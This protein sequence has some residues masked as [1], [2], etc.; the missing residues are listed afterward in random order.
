MAKL[1]RRQRQK[2]ILWTQYVLF[3]LVIGLVVLA[4]DWGT[5]KESFFRT[6]LA[7]DMFPE[8]ITMPCATP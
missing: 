3:V 6:D 7:K 4:A 5:L 8:V 1:K 2:L